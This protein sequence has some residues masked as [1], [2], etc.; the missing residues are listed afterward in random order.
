MLLGG[1]ALAVGFS[2]LFGGIGGN[3]WYRRGNFWTDSYPRICDALSE[4]SKS[5]Y[6]GGHHSHPFDICFPC[7]LGLRN[8]LFVGVYWCDL[9]VGLQA[10]DGSRHDALP[11]DGSNAHGLDRI[12]ASNGFNGN[13]V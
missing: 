11:A 4:A 13:D 6:V 3:L 5:H 9:G 1:V 7:C 2:F 10:V 8:R 12:W